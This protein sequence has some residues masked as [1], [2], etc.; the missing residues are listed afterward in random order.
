[1]NIRL[2]YLFEHVIKV[3]EK[4]GGV[5][6]EDIRKMKFFCNNRNK[7]LCSLEPISW[8]GNKENNLAM[9]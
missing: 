4:E 7:G 9:L 8:F 3:I 6:N 1:M 5:T 2:T